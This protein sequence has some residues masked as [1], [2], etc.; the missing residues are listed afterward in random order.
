MSGQIQPIR[1]M[2]DVLPA[3]NVLW[4]HLER[5]VRDLLV[6]YG[7]EE[8]R[9][10]VVE[11]T[12]LFKRAIGE[13]TDVVEK[14]MYTF[15]DQGGDS[16]TLR[17]EATAGVVRAMISNGLLRGARH[18]LWCIG[19]MF[20]HEKPQKGR[21]R[22]FHQ[23]DVEAVGFAGPDVDAELIALTARLW[24]RLG[25]ARVTLQIN[26]LGT[27]QA[28]RAYREKL[29]EYFSAHHARLDEDS[30]RRLHGNPLRILDSK[31]PELQQLIAAAPLLT[32]YLDAESEA[33]FAALRSSLTAMGVAYTVN[34][35]LVRG[36]DYYSRTVFE[37]ITDALGAQ[38]AVC[39]G[40][41]YDGLITQLGGEATP[42]IGF[43]MGIER[44]VEL[45]RQL[46]EQPQS[47]PADVYVVVNGERAAVEAGR[48]VE[49]LRDALPHRRFEMNLGGGNFKAQFRRADRSRAALALIIG[50]DELTRG[51]AALKPLRL[52]AGQSECPMG[53]LP[54][55]IEAALR[56]A[57]I[58]ES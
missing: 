6:A 46:P 3:E 17:P 57:A 27:V 19:P 13:Y 11:H 42:A 35:R 12:E 9:V 5:T 41:R 15:I 45:L 40:G 49:S 21:Y 32:D 31:N 39:S 52:E 25:I 54:V 24:R 55:R 28:R 56:A 18:K 4:Q 14:E 23:V 29:V 50:E 48:V 44:V 16:L 37:W 2:N 22:Q 1:G 36:L 34:P 47:P 58:Q 26:S 33:H 51:V 20:R 43:A 10:P 53:E 8:I 30:R 7:Y 38:D